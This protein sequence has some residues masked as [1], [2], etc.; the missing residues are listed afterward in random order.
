MPSDP[1]S[2]VALTFCLELQSQAKTRAYPTRASSVISF[3]NSTHCVHQL[4]ISKHQIASLCLFLTVLPISTQQ[5]FLCFCLLCWENFSRSSRSLKRAFAISDT[6]KK[7][8]AN[9]TQI[10][11]CQSL[12]HFRMADNPRIDPSW[13]PDAAQSEIDFSESSFSKANGPNSRLP[14]AEVRASSG[15]NETH[16]QP[17][18]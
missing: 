16:P 17:A 11:F 3:S 1:L 2:V 15:E 13:A 14:P 12:N 4:S 8:E 7:L 6:A 5:G 9:L 18:Q 10:H